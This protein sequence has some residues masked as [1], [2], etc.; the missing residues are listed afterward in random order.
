MKENQREAEVLQKSL[1]DADESRRHNLNAWKEELLEIIYSL[2]LCHESLFIWSWLSL[3][4]W[5]HVLWL[6]L[7]SIPC[8]FLFF[9]FVA[10]M[11]N[12]AQWSVKMVSESVWVCRL[13]KRRADCAWIPTFLSGQHTAQKPVAIVTLAA[14]RLSCCVW[15]LHPHQ[16]K[17]F[18]SFRGSC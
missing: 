2:L 8:C 6:R 9:F 10:I 1:V 16:Y 12:T 4:H 14:A 13:A 15:T 18:P 17:E 11:V 3:P 5:E 7:T